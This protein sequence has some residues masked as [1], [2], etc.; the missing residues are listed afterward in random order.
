MYERRSLH[1]QAPEPQYLQFM[2]YL[3]MTYPQKNDNYG[4]TFTLRSTVNGSQC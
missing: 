2:A 3:L 1:L 4:W